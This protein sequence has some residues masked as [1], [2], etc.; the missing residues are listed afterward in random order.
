MYK[1]LNDLE[2]S[3]DKCSLQELAGQI[4]EHATMYGTLAVCLTDH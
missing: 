2:L 1:I 3:V 4:G